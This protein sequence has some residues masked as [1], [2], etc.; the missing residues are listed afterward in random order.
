M[1]QDDL[2]NLANFMRNQQQESELTVLQKS[3]ENLQDVLKPQK[4][5][6]ESL[7]G[8]LGILLSFVTI[9]GIGFSSYNNIENSVRENSI[10]IKNV[11]EKVCS[12]VEKI[13]LHYAQ[14]DKQTSKNY[15]KINNHTSK[16]SELERFIKDNKSN[17]KNITIDVVENTANIK[18]I[19]DRY[20]YRNGEYNE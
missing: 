13:D 6:M 3:I 18:V 1:Q 9:L 14:I 11:S 8:W 12:V 5:I 7:N 17:I 10:N 2:Q 19:L 20:E 4:N 16:L 15:D